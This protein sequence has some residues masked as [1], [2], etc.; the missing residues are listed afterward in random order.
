MRRHY[1]ST[2]VDPHR[3]VRFLQHLSEAFLVAG[4]LDRLPVAE[5]EMALLT[6]IVADGE[7]GRRGMGS[8]AGP[9]RFV[10]LDLVEKVVSSARLPARPEQLLGPCGALVELGLE[11]SSDGGTGLGVG[12]VLGGVWRS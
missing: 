10:L 3:R 5:H 12:D 9:A 11:A 2:H 6:G 1:L 7:H 8:P 4:N